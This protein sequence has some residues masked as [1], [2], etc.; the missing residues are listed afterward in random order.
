MFKIEGKYANATV[1][2]SVIDSAAVSQ[3][4]AIC[5]APLR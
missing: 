2:A 5:N 1:Y 4:Q 3:I